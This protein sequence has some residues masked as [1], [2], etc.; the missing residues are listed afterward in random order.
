M[1]ASK[2]APNNKIV[3][4]CCG[5]DEVLDLDPK[6]ESAQIDGRLKWLAVT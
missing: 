2:L 5:H 3:F 1:L 6:K 4:G